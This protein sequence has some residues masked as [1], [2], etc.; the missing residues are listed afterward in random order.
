M[1]VEVEYKEIE[2]LKLD[3]KH[4]QDLAENLQKKLNSLDEK[5]LLND[6]YYLAE[7]LASKYIQAILISIGFE[8]T[9]DYIMFRS[10]AIRFDRKFLEHNLGKE[11]YNIKDKLNIELCAVITKTFK[12][13]F[14]D[15]GVKPEFL[16]ER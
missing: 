10:E 9:E 7:V 4:Y 5:K 16:K 12:K 11:W 15:I 8:D 6:S 13:A 14:V 3:I 1:K 2:R